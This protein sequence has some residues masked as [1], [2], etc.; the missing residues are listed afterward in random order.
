MPLQLYGDYTR[1]EVKNVF[2]PEDLFSPG[3]GRWGGV[4]IV[5]LPG[6]PGD[7][8]F[9][10]T[11]GKIQGDHAFDEGIDRAGVLRWQ[12]Q[13][14]QGFAAARIQRLLRHDAAKNVIHLFLRSSARGEG[15][16][17]PYTY[18]GRL[19]AAGYDRER[20]RPVHFKWQLLDWPIPAN[21]LSRIGL[22]L[23]GDPGQDVRDDV[24]DADVRLL[25][26]EAPPTARDFA[27][28]TRMFQAKQRRRPPEQVTRAL[29]L[30]GELAVFRHERQTLAAAG[31]ADLAD[32]VVHTSV[33]EGDGAGFD[34]QSWT[35]DGRRKFVEVKTT[36]GPKETDF[37]ISANEVA[38]AQEHLS[39]YELIRIFDF[40]RTTGHASFYRVSG[41]VTN[42]MNLTPTTFRARISSPALGGSCGDASD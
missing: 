37:F 6:R 31:R 2:A 38:F 29:G 3:A 27:E 36:T 9:L 18:L 8:A 23:E 19:A 26:E 30:A 35:C 41:A 17:R 13:P 40:D 15:S 42:S 16:T 1:E 4:G 12:S 5:Q 39:D 11:L 33:M 34:I 32:L 24:E 7:F 25:I 21:E 14:N 28:S 20:E 10:V 22:T